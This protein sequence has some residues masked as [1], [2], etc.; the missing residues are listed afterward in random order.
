MS[1]MLY[2]KQIKSDELVKLYTTQ[3]FTG[4]FAKHSFIDEE[5]KEF[6][7]IFID[8]MSAIRMC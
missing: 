6:V 4:K 7:A 5:Y 1:I 3:K 8:D 2:I